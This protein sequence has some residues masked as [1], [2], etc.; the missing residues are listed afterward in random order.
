LLCASASWTAVLFRRPVMTLGCPAAAVAPAA[1][2]VADV[3]AV[4]VLAAAA[5]GFV[6]MRVMK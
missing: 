4:T 6:V 1:A 5:A 2:A 3:V